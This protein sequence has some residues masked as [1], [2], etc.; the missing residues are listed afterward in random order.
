M[1]SNLNYDQ[2]QNIRELVEGICLNTKINLNADVP[3]RID[4]ETKRFVNE[5]MSPTTDTTTFENAIRNNGVG[6][7]SNDVD[8]TNINDRFKKPCSDDNTR[9]VEKKS[10]VTDLVMNS[11]QVLTQIFLNDDEKMKQ[12]EWEESR[13]NVIQVINLECVQPRDMD[14]LIEKVKIT[15]I[16]TIDEDNRENDDD[17]ED[18]ES[19]TPIPKDDTLESI[20]LTIETHNDDDKKKCL[21]DKEDGGKGDD[22]KETCTEDLIPRSSKSLPSS[23]AQSHSQLSDELR[24]EKRKKWNLNKIW[25]LFIKKHKRSS[26]EKNA[27]VEK[28]N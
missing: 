3:S 18:N 1:S 11:K 28:R 13:E 21:N 16:D 4:V 8:R 15:S 22:F 19:F 10:R 25:N 27:N 17:D 24:K 7:Q 6:D 2:E 20:D 23:S 5:I 14:K 9:I 26:D 12:D